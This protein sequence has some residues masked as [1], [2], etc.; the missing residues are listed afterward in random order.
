M[1]S[2][3]ARSV[4]VMLALLLV[5]SG[6]DQTILS[7]ALPSIVRAL[8]GQALAPWVFS[9]YLMAATAAVPL[10]GKLA[11]RWGLRPMLLL[12]SGLFTIGS[13]A[14]ALAPSMAALVA[15]G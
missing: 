6:L 10:Y 11:D 9:A 1:N 2:Q 13:L 12:A 8:Q 14:C 4:Y 3:R 5:L 7:T 15:A